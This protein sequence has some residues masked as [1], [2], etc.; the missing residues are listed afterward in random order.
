MYEWV[1]E[2]DY[3]VHPQSEQEQSYWFAFGERGVTYQQLNNRI[4]TQRNSKH[5]ATPGF[6][7]P[8]E[9]WLC[10]LDGTAPLHKQ[11][12]FLH[13]Q[14]VPLFVAALLGIL[15]QESVMCLHAWLLIEDCLDTSFAQLPYY[16][17][18]FIPH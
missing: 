17:S 11:N 18:I 4:H 14:S 1:R 10:L 16:W 12:A 15:M 8:I 6:Y 3:R 13:E 7:R 9:V 2:Y 5:K